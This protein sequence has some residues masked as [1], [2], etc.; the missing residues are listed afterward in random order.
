MKK[1]NILPI[2]IAIPIVGLILSVFLLHDIVAGL[3]VMIGVT[4]GIASLILMIFYPFFGLLSIVIVNQFDNFIFLPL[5]ATAGR[6]IGVMVALGWFLKYFYGRKTIFFELLNINKIALLFIISMLA[7]SLLA[8]APLR[9]FNIVLTTTLLITMMFFMQDFVKDTKD[10][11]LLILI[12]ALSVGISS[13]VG[14][15]QYKSLL[16]GAQ[17]MGT[18][19]YEG[20]D[21]TARVAGLT[22]NP[23]GYAVM[24]MAGIP[25]LL[26]LS[27]NSSNFFLKF[28]SILLFLTSIISLGLT[29]SRTNIYG[30]GAFLFFFILIYFK[31]KNITKNQFSI[32]LT[33]LIIVIF[34]GSIFLFDF[35][36]QRAFSFED[37]SSGIRYLI[38]SKGIN[39]FIEHPLWGI[40]FGNFE[41]L[42][43]VDNK[44]VNIQG[45][46]G[47]DIMSVPFVSTGAIGTFLLILLCFKTYNYFNS[48]AIYLTKLN[49]K[50]LC[51]LICIL[52][53]AFIALLLTGFGNPIIFQRIFWIYIALAS[54]IY[55]WSSL[56]INPMGKIIFR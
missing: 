44:Y 53:S 27:L 25:F 37:S 6:M 31:S 23:N 41:L 35:I 29:L 16:I 54:I 3:Y 11:R 39:L 56:R 7:S 10:L 24:L 28:I 1:L 2:I 19:L 15:I 17:S 47:H 45:R 50:Y 42:D 22:L 43:T 9:S 13:L 32:L 36:K 5:S 51:N 33:I 52:K 4:I 26:F 49:E 18:V 20:E 40:G 38:F 8:T 30:F 14:V 48:A 12:I 55:R 21:H 34:L 46:P